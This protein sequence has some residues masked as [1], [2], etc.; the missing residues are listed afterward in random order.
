MFSAHFSI[1]VALLV[2]VGF[3]T[4]FADESQ[5]LTGTIGKEKLDDQTIV[6]CELGTQACLPVSIDGDL[7]VQLNGENTSVL[8]IPIG[9]FVE[10]TYSITLEGQRSVSQI[11]ADPTKTIVC[12]MS[13]GESEVESVSRLLENQHAIS[14]FEFISSSK[15][16][17]IEYE[18]DS[19]SYFEIEKLITD[20]G[21]VIE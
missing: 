11:E 6:I 3:G 20:A 16:V 15:Q 12:F 5:V 7:K 21:F 19:I 17:L 18:P 1:I 2:L 8:D 13:L 4:G 9:T 10:V 14:S